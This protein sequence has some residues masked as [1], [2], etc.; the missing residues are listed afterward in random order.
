MLRQGMSHADHGFGTGFCGGNIFEK[1]V[2]MATDWHLS[3]TE[4]S[5]PP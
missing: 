4:L 3:D 5:L 1:N 2:G